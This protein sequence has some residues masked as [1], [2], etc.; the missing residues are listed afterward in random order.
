MKVICTSPSFAKYSNQPIDRLKEAGIELIRVPADIDQDTFIEAAADADAAIVAFNEINES[1]LSKLPKLKIISKHGVGVDNID[2]EATKK[3]GVLVTNVPNA[4]KH[5]VA[6]YSFSL[7]LSLARLIP[8]GNQKTKAGEWPHLFGSDIHSKT[9]GIIGLGA[10]GK[11]VAKRSTGFQM[12]VLAYDPYIDE[13][14][15]KENQIQSVDLETLLKES[16]FVTLHM[17]LI[18]QTRHLLNANRLNMMKETAFLV[19]A[20]RGGIIDESALYD[21][22]LNKQ[23]AGAALDVF[24]NEPV[25]ESPLYSLDNFV[26]MPHVAG[27]TPGAINILSE[28]C[29]DNIVSVL[30]S[31]DQP[32]HIVHSS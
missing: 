3:Y 19:N 16:D 10:I 8:Y 2:L 6:D 14:Y 28:V 26:A 5:A 11:E 25:K 13:T 17:P 9:L 21:A 24:E 20:S 1:V 27:Y 30:T 7:L 23:I 31:T 15:A 12:N 32:K 22:L 18:E 29:V 4:N